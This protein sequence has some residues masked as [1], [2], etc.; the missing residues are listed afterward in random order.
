MVHD[1]YVMQ[2]KTP[3]ESKYPWDYYK[4]VKVMTGEEAYGPIPASARWPTVEVHPGHAG[5]RPC[6]RPTF[7]CE[8]G[9]VTELFGFPLPVILGQLMLGLVNGSFYAML[10]LGW[11]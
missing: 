11:R 5:A 7:S 6:S 3:A 10:S 8:P 9:F 2:V 4:V 1:M